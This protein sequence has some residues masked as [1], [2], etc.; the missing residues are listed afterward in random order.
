VIEKDIVYTLPKLEIR[1]IQSGQYLVL[2]WTPCNQPPVRYVVSGWAEGVSIEIGLGCDAKPTQDRKLTD[3]M[4]YDSSA[5]VDSW[6]ATIPDAICTAVDVIP[7]SK[8]EII[9][10]ASKESTFADLLLS[11]PHLAWLSYCRFRDKLWSVN[12]YLVLIAQK[13]HIIL[14]ELD[15]PATRSA[16]KILRNYS[17]CSFTLK[18]LETIMELLRA[19][20][21]RR[22]FAHRSHLHSEQIALILRFPHLLSVPFGDLIVAYDDLGLIKSLVW[23]YT[24]EL[25]FEY[26]KD[27]EKCSNLKSLRSLFSRIDAEV[28]FGFEDDNGELLPLPLLPDGKLIKSLRTQDALIEHGRVGNLCL[29]SYRHEAMKGMMAFY[30]VSTT[31]TPITFSVKRLASGNLV[32]SE[33]KAYSNRQPSASQIRY[34]NEWFT[35]AVYVQGLC[36]E[37]KQSSGDVC[38]L[39]PNIELGFIG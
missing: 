35:S 29:S 8:L 33:I 15:L 1:W 16:A 9:A 38:V 2:N 25:H 5:P 17:G 6:K 7:D 11:N 13:Q 20:K 23:I 24:C 30:V 10:F 4:Y 37:L 26:V 22:F 21:T 12:K 3:W 27:I 19:D 34:V 28:Y 14:K 36:S 31:P 32:L 18:N 39:M